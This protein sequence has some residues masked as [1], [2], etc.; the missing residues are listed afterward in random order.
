M[1]DKE[2]DD[3]FVDLMRK[4]NATQPKTK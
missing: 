3:F 4:A 2:E 1:K